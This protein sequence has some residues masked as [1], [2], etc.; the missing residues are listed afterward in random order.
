[1]VLP[2]VLLDSH[3]ANDTRILEREINQGLVFFLPDCVTV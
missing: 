2:S 3:L 1:M